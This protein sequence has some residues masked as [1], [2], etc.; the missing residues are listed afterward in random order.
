MSTDLAQMVTYT[1][2]KCDNCGSPKV[3]DD[4][5]AA[6][7]P[8]QCDHCKARNIKRVGPYVEPEPV[9]SPEEEARREVEDVAFGLVIEIEGDVYSLACDGAIGKLKAVLALLRK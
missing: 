3:L 5:L 6:A 2:F 8:I 7:G 9:V 1:E 4:Y